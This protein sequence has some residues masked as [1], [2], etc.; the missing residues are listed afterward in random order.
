MEMQVAALAA[1]EEY[2]V[3]WDIDAI[4]SD[5]FSR[6]YI[7]IPTSKLIPQ[8]WLTVDKEYAMTTDV[9]KP[10]ILF[11]LPGNKAYIADGNHRLYHAAQENIP[12]MKVIAVPEETHLQYLFR[13]TRQ[14]YQETIRRLLPEGIFIDKP[15]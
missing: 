8:Q 6:A 11:E 4:I 15:Y 13:S 14:D 7:T 10:L 2:I 3:M 5:V 12:T 9:T 1:D